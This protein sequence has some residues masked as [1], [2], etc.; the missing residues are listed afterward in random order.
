MLVSYT[1]HHTHKQEGKGRK[2]KGKGER[3]QERKERERSKV[4]KCYIW[5]IQVKGEGAL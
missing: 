4:V 1:L 5:G 3:E 2:G